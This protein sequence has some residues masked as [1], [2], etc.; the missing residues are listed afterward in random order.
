MG[1]TT[2]KSISI[3]PACHE[4][5]KTIGNTHRM[6]MANTVEAI[7]SGWNSLTPMQRGDAIRNQYETA[8]ADDATD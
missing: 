5:I 4:A 7:V 3:R 2:I 8:E 6:N 1:T